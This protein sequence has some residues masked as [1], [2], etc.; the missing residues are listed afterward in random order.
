MYEVTVAHKG[1]RTTS[2]ISQIPSRNTV[3]HQRKAFPNSSSTSE[4]RYLRICLKIGT[5]IARPILQKHALAKLNCAY[6]CMRTTTCER[7]AVLRSSN[8]RLAWKLLL[9]Q[10]ALLPMWFR[11]ATPT[12]LSSHRLAGRSLLLSL[13][14][15]QS[16][17]WAEGWHAAAC[18]LQWLLGQACTLSTVR[19][20]A[21]HALRTPFGRP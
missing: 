13:H 2:L 8:A 15:P 7:G 6:T 12:A 17:G 20:I 16:R 4:D 14:P 3:S 10:A 5:S 18:A 19:S 9:H 21:S 11:S 1:I